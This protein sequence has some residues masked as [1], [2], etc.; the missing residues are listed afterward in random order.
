[1]ILECKRF[2]SS[3]PKSLSDDAK[4]YV[5]GHKVA[6]EQVRRGDDSRECNLLSRLIDQYAW[7]RAY[8]EHVERFIK[9]ENLSDV[10]LDYQTWLR[11]DDE[12]QA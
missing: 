6:L 2:E 5:L 12:K 1:M 11:K 8:I 9:G 7:Q 10:P 3:L 4:S